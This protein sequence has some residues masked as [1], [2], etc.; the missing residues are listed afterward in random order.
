M[1]N[2][3][4]LPEK[5]FRRGLWLLALVFAGFLI[6]LGGTLV[7]D[8][9]K[10]ESRST[11]ESYLDPATL[12]S[13]ESGIQ[14]ARAQEKAAQE[15]M[16]QAQL[17]QQSAGSDLA[18][19]REALESWLATRQATQRKEEDT[20]LIERTRRVDA[21]Q[22]AAREAEAQVQRHR[23]DLLN[24]RQRED[25]LA[26]ER[27]RHAAEAREKWAAH[28]RW[29][30]LRVFL[31]RLALTLP[32]LV[33]AGW[34]LRRHR[35]GRWWP[36]VWGFAG[37]AGFTFFVELVPYLPS[38]GGYVRYAVGIVV[39]VIVGHQA[40]LALERYRQRQRQVEA[41]PDDVRRQELSHDTALAR[42]E[43]GLCPGC[44]RALKLQPADADFCPHCGICLFN[45]CA[46][47]RARKSAFARY[48][49]RC[50]VAAGSS[51]GAG[52]APP[53]PMSSGVPDGPGPAPA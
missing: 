30:E 17:R 31:Y 41:Q 38:Y 45:A 32:P 20:Q 51:P 3:T 27:T 11:P 50:G 13:L 21:L 6:G 19:A 44:E 4:R 26:R 18:A 10:V 43:K 46:A 9:P 5:W 39:S 15:A 23:Q 35:Q 47:C 2:A 8:L 42:L 33:I 12:Q 40:I 52:A 48:C 36:F 22:Q 53:A 14:E 29:L 28:Y 24:A 1:T 37:F 34:L 16:A 7:G 49:A 25:G